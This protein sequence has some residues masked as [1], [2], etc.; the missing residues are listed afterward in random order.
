VVEEGK[1]GRAMGW[2]ALFTLERGVRERIGIA[3]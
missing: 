3:S 2:G 1:E